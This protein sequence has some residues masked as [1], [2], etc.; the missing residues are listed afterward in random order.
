MLQPGRE[1]KLL[2][3]EP[4]TE[5]GVLRACVI[6]EK[7]RANDRLPG[8]ARAVASAAGVALNPICTRT[9]ASREHESRHGQDHLEARTE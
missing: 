4:P 9:S 1:V 7:S 8:V 5:D 3:V 2:Q 6:F